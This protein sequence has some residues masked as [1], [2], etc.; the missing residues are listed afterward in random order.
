MQSSSNGDYNRYLVDFK[1]G[2]ER[3][4]ATDGTL[5][6]YKSAQDIALVELAL[7]HPIRLGLAL[8]F[9]VFYYEIM[10][11]A[12]KACALAKRL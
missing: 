12:K 4:E 6:A 11:M 10:N 9:S 8:N 3:K 2:E 1:A 5:E 7:M